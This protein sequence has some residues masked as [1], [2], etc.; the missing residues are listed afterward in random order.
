MV[1]KDCGTE[2]DGLLCPNCGAEPI[3]SEKGVSIVEDR[4]VETVDQEKEAEQSHG[5]LKKIKKFLR[6]R[7]YIAVVVIVLIAVLS[8]GGG[9]SEAAKNVTAEIKTL[10]NISKKSDS[11]I[12]R[13]ERLYNGLSDTD[14]KDVKNYDKLQ[15][16]RE[17][18]DELIAGDIVE[19]IKNLK[20][21][22]DK[23]EID[24]IKTEYNLLTDNQKTY[25][26]NYSRLDELINA[27]NLKLIQNVEKLIDSISYV[28]GEITDSESKAI[29]EAL[30]AYNLLSDVNKRDV[31]NYTKLETAIDGRDSY[32]LIS[33]QQKVNN[34]ILSGKGYAEAKIAY[35]KLSEGAKAKIKDYD[36]LEMKEKE[37]SIK[38][39]L[40]SQPL[41]V[42]STKYVVQDSRYKALYPDMLQAVIQNNTKKDIKNAVIAFVAWDANKLPVKIKASGFETGEATYIRACDYNDI[43]L[44][45][46]AKFGNNCGF[47]VDENCGIKYLKAI[48]LSYETFDGEEWENPL[49]EEWG[50]LYAGKRLTSE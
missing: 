10:T 48:V 11:D 42:V 9:K 36:K 49:F 46:G 34:A 39:R 13:V 16:A 50:E 30:S 17:K 32:L 8:G 1:C 23:K 44:I 22:A 3:N 41:T 2:F 28:S 25:V 37:I 18:C 26:S 14:K 29:D 43:N 19:K 31:S 45:P 21:D 20:N 12:K 15:R 40:S 6:K 35:D 27:Y 4:S 47:E 24:V 38:N 33:V 5:F 7:W